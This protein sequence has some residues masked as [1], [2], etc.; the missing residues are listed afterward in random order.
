[1]ATPNVIR[2]STL[3]GTDAAQKLV[4]LARAAFDIDLPLKAIK[5]QGI[6]NLNLNKIRNNGRIT[7][8]VAE[9]RRASGGFVANVSPVELPLIIRLRVL[10]CRESFADSV[11]KRKVVGSWRAW[12]GT[13][14]HDG[15]RFE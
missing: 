5:K 13:L 14:A 9:C 7:R 6:E 10:R 8:L 11:S 4:L 1:M 3:N 2:N 15:S 12:C